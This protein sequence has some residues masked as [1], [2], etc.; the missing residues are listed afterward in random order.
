[1]QEQTFT[2]P[3]IAIMIRAFDLKVLRL[4]LQNPVH[5]DA[6]RAR[7]PGDPTATDLGNWHQFEQTN[8]SLFAGMYSLWL[9]RAGK[10]EVEDPLAWIEEG[11][12]ALG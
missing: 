3:Q 12:E 11:D 10:Q 2:L 6:Y 1:M 9:G 7:F 8:P 5:L 4:D